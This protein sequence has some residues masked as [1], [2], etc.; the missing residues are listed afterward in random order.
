[1]KIKDD[2]LLTVGELQERLHAFPPDYKIFFGTNSLQFYRLK[3]R[4]PGL[5]QLEFSQV[6]SEDEAG[7]VSIG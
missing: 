1:M 4:G 2:D 3:L 6:V 7:N 5:V